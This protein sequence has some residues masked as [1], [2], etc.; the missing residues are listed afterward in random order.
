[1]TQDA[2]SKTTLTTLLHRPQRLSPFYSIMKR[3]T[4]HSHTYRGAKNYQAVT[5]HGPTRS[6]SSNLNRAGGRTPV[7]P[8][9]GG[10]SRMLRSLILRI[11]FFSSFLVLNKIFLKI[12]V[13]NEIYASSVVTY[14]IFEFTFQHVILMLYS[15]EPPTL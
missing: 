9:R 12:F 7:S 5:V 6:G 13:H 14:F 2:E 15:G 11:D 4:Q 10:G 1:M 3:S 8:G